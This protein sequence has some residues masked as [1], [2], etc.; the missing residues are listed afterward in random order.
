MIKGLLVKHFMVIKIRKDPAQIPRT[1]D[2][3]KTVVFAFGQVASQVFQR[4][5][6]INGL[7]C[8]VHL[9]LDEKGFQDIDLF[10]G[11][12]VAAAEFP[13]IGVKRMLAKKPAEENT[14]LT[15]PLATYAL[16]KLGECRR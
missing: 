5:S 8:R 13:R 1:I 16:A 7:W 14:L 15:P 9:L 2:D 6:F 4:E 10:T 3:G 12:E 11:F